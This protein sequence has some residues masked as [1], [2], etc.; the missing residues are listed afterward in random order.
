MK[1]LKRVTS[2]L[3]FTIC[4]EKWAYVS[5]RL[6]GDEAAVTLISALGV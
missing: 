1:L 3:L 4:R 6:D 2:L 5:G